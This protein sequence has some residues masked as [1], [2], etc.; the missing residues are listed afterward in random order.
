MAVQQKTKAP[1]FFVCLGDRSKDSWDTG[2]SESS[3]VTV[4]TNGCLNCCRATDLNIMLGKNFLPLETEKQRHNST[5][6]RGIMN[7][8]LKP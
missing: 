1:F 8:N 3:L 7:I 4:R 5:L 6:P 2:Q